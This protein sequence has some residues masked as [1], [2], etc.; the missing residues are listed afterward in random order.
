MSIDL[1]FEPKDWERIQHDW[2]AW[3]HHELDRPMVVINAY[4]WEGK[5]FIQQ[6]NGWNEAKNLSPIDPVLDYYQ[7]VLENQRFYGDSWPR[8]LPNF[9]PGIVA[10]F[11]GASVGS[12]DRTVW[13]EPSEKSNLADLHLQ[14]NENNF[15]WRWVQELIQAA[16]QRWG[17]QVTVA[18]PDLG[19][20]L[21]IL[22]SF[23]T[24]ENLLMDLYDTPAEID[25]LVSEVTGLWLQ[26]YDE[27]YR[28]IQPVGNGTTAWTPVWCSERYY[29]LQSDFAYMIS[30]QMFERFALP[31]L[32]DCCQH[33]D[34]A[35]YHLDGKGQIPHLDMLLSLERLRGIQWIPG[36]GQPPA[37]EW[38]PMLKRIRDGGKLCQ[39]YASP[40]AVRTIVRELGGKGFAFW[41]TETI[42]E[43]DII[44]LLR[45]IKFE[46]RLSK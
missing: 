44:G 27:L 9:G 4:E 13:F 3:W 31:D 36:D 32:A 12:D 18:H 26:Y 11:L 20:N 46:Y 22:A 33:L 8:W 40:K 10:G 42:S 24:T 28:F 15:W 41:I 21:D 37:E 39:V 14:Y 5:A 19:G 29:M 2:T 7:Q 45:E 35:F 16:I 30:P 25:R 1:H 6:H 17:D 38:L 43:E 23:R 34:Y